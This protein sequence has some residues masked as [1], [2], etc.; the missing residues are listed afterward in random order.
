MVEEKKGGSSIE[1]EIDDFISEVLHKEKP[2]IPKDIDLFL[3]TEKNYIRICNG[4]FRGGKKYNDIVLLETKKLEPDRG[5]ILAVFSKM[6]FL[7]SKLIH[8]YVIDYDATKREIFDHLHERHLSFHRKIG[9]LHD[10]KKIDNNDDCKKLI[11]LKKVRN[12][13]AHAW[14]NK[15]VYYEGIPIENNFNKFKD[16]LKDIWLTLVNIYKEEQTKIDIEEI[17]K[18]MKLI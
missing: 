10:W 7:L 8:L 18:K 11:E 13:F 12:G 2:H 9:L 17:K 16:D 3:V 15:E 14:D 4:L 1:N 5:K 6:E